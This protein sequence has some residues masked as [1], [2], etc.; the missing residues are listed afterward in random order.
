VARAFESTVVLISSMTWMQV[1]A[2][3]QSDDRCVLPLGS[4]EQHA[5]ISLA[6]D[7]IL[8]ERVA[9]AAAEP[10]GIPVFP[11]LTYGITPYFMGYPGTVT[12][13]PA[14]YERV[15]GEILAGISRHGFRRL[16]VVNGHGGNSPARP[17]AE[18]WAARREGVSIRWHDWWK[19]PRVRAAIDEEDPAASHASWMETFPWT[20][21]DGVSVPDGHKAPVDLADRDEL[22]PARLREVLGDGSFG[23][24]YE[25]PA[26]VMERIWSVAVDETRTRLTEGWDT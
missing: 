11:A 2:Y 20:R 12:L 6:T 3:L 1:E 15:L 4:T 13:S 24:Y 14:T 16:L 7:S 19:A 23:G 10:L 25:R 18:V 8:A 21:V 17:A 9:A 26:E 22:S 5:H